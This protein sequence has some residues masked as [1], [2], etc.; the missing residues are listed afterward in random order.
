MKGVAVKWICRTSDTEE[1]RET[2]RPCAW[3]VYLYDEEGNAYMDGSA[4]RSRTL[5]TA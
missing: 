5:V 2:R 4:A 1:P 3:E